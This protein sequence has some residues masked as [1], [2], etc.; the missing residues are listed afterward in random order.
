MSVRTKAVGAAIACILGLGVGLFTANA[1]TIDPGVSPEKKN[2]IN[3]A[4]DL[5]PTGHNADDMSGP[6]RLPAFAD[7][8]SE[9][10]VAKIKSV[11]SN[12]LTDATAPGRIEKGTVLS[13]DPSRELTVKMQSR[14]ENLNLGADKTE[15]RRKLLENVWA[16]KSDVDFSLKAN[17]EGVQEEV[18]QGADLSSAF[19]HNAFVLEGF[20]GVRVSGD[21]AYVQLIGYM[22][23]TSADGTKRPNPR[24]Q[25]KIDL[26]RAPQATYGWLIAERKYTDFWE[27]GEK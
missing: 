14:N 11:I 1:M 8:G 13:E 4:Q 15:E 5:E 26:V 24:A 16:N 12:L 7:A 21:T 23:Y 10:D 18:I 6:K 22:D 17:N 25:Y 27:F 20:E 2:E 9:G 3:E 19:V